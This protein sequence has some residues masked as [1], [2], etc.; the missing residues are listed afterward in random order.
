MR[1][2]NWLAASAGAPVRRR[3]GAVELDNVVFL[4]AVVAQR[5]VLGQTQDNDTFHICLRAKRVPRFTK[6]LKEASALQALSEMLRGPILDACVAV[7][8]SELDEDGQV[9]FKG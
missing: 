7:Y 5:E 2:L 6:R 3:I 4:S 9:D 8:I 1:R